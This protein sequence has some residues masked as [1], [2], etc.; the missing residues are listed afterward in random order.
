M[1]LLLEMEQLEHH[2]LIFE[3]YLTGADMLTNQTFRN[4]F[5]LELFQSTGGMAVKDTSRMFTDLQGSTELYDRIGD[6]KAFSLVHH[7]FDVLGDSV[8]RNNGAIVKTIGDAI[9]AAFQSSADTLTAAI[10]MRDAIKSYNKNSSDEDIYIKIGIH[11]GAAIA[12]TLN[13][14]LDYF[15]QSINI[16]ARIQGLAN[17]DEI[18]MTDSI[19]EAPNVK[20][21][22]SGRT[23]KRKQEKLKGIEMPFNV[24]KI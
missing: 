12:V 22:L 14:R 17:G 19:L 10:E 23:L 24:Y 8:I 2:Q 15:G 11:R 3:P 16:A 6:L 4:I 18:Y 9:M 21:I 1:I 13:E 20:K 5:N 7:H